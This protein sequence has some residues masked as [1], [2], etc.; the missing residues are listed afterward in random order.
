VK[1]THSFHREQVMCGVRMVINTTEES[2]RSI[3]ADV[4]RQEMPATRVLLHKRTDVVNE[5]GDQDQRALGSLLLEA[6]PRN[7]GKIVAVSGPSELILGGLKFLELHGQNTLLDFVIR[8]DLEMGGQSENVHRLDE[9]LGWV[10]L[11]PPDSVP[12]VHGE[13]VVEVVVTFT[14][15]DKSGD[16]V[17]ARTVL[18]IEGGLSEIMSQGVNSERRVVDEAQTKETSVDVST[19]PVSPSKA[20]NES[21]EHVGHEQENWEIVIVLPFNDGVFPQVTDVCNTSFPPWFNEHPAKVGKEEAFVGVV[22]IKVGVGVTMVGTVLC[23]PPFNRTLN[24]TGTGE[25]EEVLKGHRC[26]V[27]TMRP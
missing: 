21:G 16:Q 14:D 20:G 17:V 5:T 24:G 19:F 23:A 27:S 6:F 15:G 18:V 8:E 1:D 10:V 9:P 3:L 12:V 2:G 26:I 22:G 7:D 4:L 13:L 25:S 11:P